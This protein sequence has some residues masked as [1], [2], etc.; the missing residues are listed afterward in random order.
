MP[1]GEYHPNAFLRKIRN[2]RAGLITRTKIIYTIRDGGLSA[3][4][5]AKLVGMSYSNV[6]HH[7]RLMEEEATVERKKG[8]R[9]FP[10]RSTGKGQQQL[11]P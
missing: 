6:L 4:D 11:P 8:S 7:L 5:T 9:P 1:K 3:G 10:W 2:V